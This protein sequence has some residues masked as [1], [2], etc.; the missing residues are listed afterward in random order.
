MSGQKITRSIGRRLTAYGEDEIFALYL[1]HGGVRPLLKNMPKEVGP[2][3]TGVFYAWLK[4]T[5]ERA[6]KWQMVQEIQ[7]STWAEEALEIVDD[8]DQDNVQVARLRSDTR[9]WLAERFNRQ[10]FGKPE[11]T[12]T[13]GIT[14]GQEFL[15]SLKK[16]EQWAKEERSAE[17]EAPVQEA[18]YEV[19]EE[20]GDPYDREG[21]DE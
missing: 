10:Q 13:I 18:E 8:A 11:L 1:Q 9:K 14:I 6:S 12:A 20:D 4:A 17:G 15:E 3:S 19:V 2:M 5:P 7:G 21:I 16:V